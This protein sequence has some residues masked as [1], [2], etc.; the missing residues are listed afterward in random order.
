MC[1]TF[2]LINRIIGSILRD[3]LCGT[4]GIPE[5]HFGDLTI[6]RQRCR[7]IIAAKAQPAIGQICILSKAAYIIFVHEFTIDVNLNL[8]FLNVAHNRNQHPLAGAD[9]NVRLPVDITIIGIF[10]IAQGI[11]NR[12]LNAPGVAA[13]AI[14]IHND[15]AAV[16]LRINFSPNLY[17][18]RNLN[19]PLYLHI[20]ILD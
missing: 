8:A 7:M 13:S 18:I 4:S 1:K 16:F 20:L 10:P 3:L 17:G 9:F 11:V 12:Y 2:C 6:Q 5:S 14:V 15:L 19:R